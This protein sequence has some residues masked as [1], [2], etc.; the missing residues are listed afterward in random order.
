MGRERERKREIEIYEGKWR[1]GDIYREIEREGYHGRER[2][3]GRSWERERERK[4]E[5]DR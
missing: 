1:Q 2:E 4:R 3:G 5:M